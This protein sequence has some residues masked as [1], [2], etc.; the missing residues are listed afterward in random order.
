[1]ARGRPQ[2][3]IDWVTV[4]KLCGIQCTGEEIASVLGID[5]DTLMRACKRKHGV[6][7]AEYSEQKRLPGR[8]SLRRRQY[9]VAMSG[10]VG[11]LVWLGKQWLDQS[12][13]VDQKVTTNEVNSTV[14]NIDLG[15][16]GVGNPNQ[17][18]GSNPSTKKTL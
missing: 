14:V 12:E 1:M 8:V 7:F 4:D 17:H 15:D 2:I 5:Y 13:K 18:Q 16:N 9:E 6:N 10:N 3:E 11:M